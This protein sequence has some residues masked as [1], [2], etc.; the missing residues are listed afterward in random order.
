MMTMMTMMM[1]M[2]MMHRSQ[3]FDSSWLLELQNSG[4]G[5]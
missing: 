1:M 4:G 5:E 3:T 2:M